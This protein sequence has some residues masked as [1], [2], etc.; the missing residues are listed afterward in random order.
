[1]NKNMTEE[2]WDLIVKPQSSWFDLKLKE[3]WR[4]RDLL[5]LFVKRDI[6][7]VYKQTIL[8]PIWFIIQPVLT[9]L[10]F[11]VVFGNMAELD[12][13]GKPKFLFYLA[14]VTCW[15]YFADCVNNTSSTFINN[16]SIFGKVYFPRLISPISIV[17]SSVLKFFIQF[18]LFFVVYCWFLFGD[19]DLHPNILL[20]WLPYLV[21]LMAVM[22]LGMGIIISS[23]TTK[24]RDLRFLITFGIQL[25]MYVTPVIMPASKF[26]GIMHDLVMLNPMS[27]II[28]FFKA[29]FFGAQTVEYTPLIYASVISFAMLAFGVLIFNRIEKTFM[30]TV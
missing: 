1:M 11:T 25:M 30:D 4:Y 13:D 3:I 28:E 7:S 18:A 16:A 2:K 12:T 22:G 26:K 17:I 24:Y 19:N 8:G 6:V 15:N 5:L 20:L 21:L 9:S 29:G 10:T 14:G 27:P 23:F